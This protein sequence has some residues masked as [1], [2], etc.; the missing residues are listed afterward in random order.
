MLG[1]RHTAR[2]IW[3]R[4]HASRH[5][6]GYVLVADDAVRL[7]GH[8]QDTGIYAVLSIPYDAIDDARVG[9]TPDEAVAG[10]QAVVLE[11]P[12]EDPIYVR[13]AIVV[14]RS[15]DDL[16]RRLNVAPPVATAYANGERRNHAH[17]Q[18]DA[19]Q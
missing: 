10:R 2:V 12:D 4:R 6:V 19:L 16:V 18:V 7:A 11:L 14:P 13:P 5:Y 3:R 9:H 8:E 1:V 15:L 17:R